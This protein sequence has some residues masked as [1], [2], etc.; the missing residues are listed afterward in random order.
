MMTRAGRNPS[1][2]QDIKDL[3]S[4]VLRNVGELDHRACISLRD[5]RQFYDILLFQFGA[6]NESSDEE[7][8]DND[9]VLK[10]IANIAFNLRMKKG[11]KNEVRGNEFESKCLGFLESSSTYTYMYDPLLY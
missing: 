1:V 7:E 4:N 5:C 2:V 3:H 9:L 6:T 11:V 10:K 8:N